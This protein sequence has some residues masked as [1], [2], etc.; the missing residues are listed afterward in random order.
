MNVLIDIIGWIGWVTVFV[1][2]FGGVYLMWAS[3]NERRRRE[4]DSEVTQPGLP[5]CVVCGWVSGVN[6]DC[7]QCERDRKVLP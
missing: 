6:R 3:M 2:V 1:F 7:S 4:S 5:T